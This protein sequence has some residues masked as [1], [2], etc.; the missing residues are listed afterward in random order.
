[1]VQISTELRDFVSTLLQR[2][3]ALVEQLAP[4]TL[5]VLAP[6]H[7]QQ[8]LRIGDLEYL[9]FGP[10]PPDGTQP[11]TLESDW[12]ER[13]GQLLGN[14]GRKARCVLRV[15][16]PAPAFPER[17]LAHA[18]SLQNAVCDLVSVSAAWTA[19]LI[20]LFR[21]TAFSDEER[22]G[23]LTLGVNLANGAAIE[24]PSAIDLFRASALPDNR[25]SVFPPASELP[26]SWSNERVNLWIKHAFP[27]RLNQHLAPFVRGLQRRLDRDLARI[28]DYY[29][30]LQRESVGR[31]RKRDGEARERLRLESIDREY[32]SKVEDLRQKYS[33]RVDVTLSQSLELI[34]PVQRFE[35]VIKRRKARRQLHLD[36][37]PLLRRLDL[38]PCESS[39]TMDPAR[40]VCDDRL[41]IVSPSAHGPCA[42]CQRAYCRACHPRKCPKCG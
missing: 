10:D 30:D 2:E 36:W 19:Y 35:L 27:P 38:P 22:D 7:M 3:G 41:H 18:V 39:L 5:E 11:V 25:Q 37:N 28:H 31:L 9:S 4:N 29:G 33:L 8:A 12:L 23:M 16:A 24:E 17:L 14:R 6:S 20:L 13:L 21:Y 34:M 32:R 26:P 42:N 1:M 40:M 15:P